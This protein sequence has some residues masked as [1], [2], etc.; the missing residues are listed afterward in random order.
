MVINERPGV[1]SSVEVS[2]SLSGS[3][4]GKT[5]GIAAV[6]AA[7]EKGV[8]KSVASYGEAVSLYGAD[9][10]LTK[11]IKVLLLNG[12]AA[13]EAVPVSVGTAATA[14]DYA[15]AFAALMD[16]EDISIMVCDSRNIEVYSKMKAAIEG[17]SEN[18]KYRIGIVESAGT[19]N[20]AANKA[21]ELNYER[22]VMVYPA[23][24]DDGALCGASAA[25]MAGLVSSGSDPALPVNGAVLSGI[26]G[27]SRVFSD[28]EINT[29]IKAGVTPIESVYGNP[30]VVRGVTTRTKTA[31]VADTT[32]RE[33]TTVLIIDDVIPSV[34][35]ALRRKFPR[36]KNTAQTRGAIRTQVIIELENKLKREIIDAYGPVTAS[37]DETDPTVCIV[38]FEFTVAHGL[39][40]IILSAHISV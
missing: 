26:D 32:W 33:L 1:Y 12:A 38:G 7:G 21:A 20:E 11:L 8:C 36:V 5:V 29:L 37:A 10:N 28:A 6:S 13:V 35:S 14:S 27:F 15:A 31:G 9:C 39:N 4:T 18:C 23:V 30:S 25:A 24:E 19:V 22:I 40:R 2:S 3:N 34:R 16:K 17:A